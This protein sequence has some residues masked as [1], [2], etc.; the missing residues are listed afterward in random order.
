MSNEL[1]SRHLFD[2]AKLKSEKIKHQLDEILNNTSIELNIFEN[3]VMELKNEYITINERK[4]KKYDVDNSV[5]KLLEKGAYLLFVD[6]ILETTRINVNQTNKIKSFIKGENISLSQKEYYSCDSIK[7]HIIKNISRYIEILEIPKTITIQANIESGIF[8]QIQKDVNYLITIKNISQKLSEFK[9]S[10][11]FKTEMK[12]NIIS[13]LENNSLYHNLEIDYLPN[14]K[15]KLLLKHFDAENETVFL[16]Y[17]IEDVIFYRKEKIDLKSQFEKI[18]K[19]HENDVPSNR[20]CFLWPIN[21][22]DYKYNYS[23]F[24][25]WR[26][27]KPKR[28]IKITSAVIYISIGEKYFTEPQQ[29]GNEFS[30]EIDLE[31]KDKLQSV[32]EWEEYK[33]KREKWNYIDEEIS[34]FKKFED[35]YNTLK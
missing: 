15:I 31:S 11:I 34:K 23:E 9:E 26:R 27:D 32:N 30:F 14:I 35:L 4:F 24:W 33:K 18:G 28:L 8:S 21:K 13:Y 17:K 29:P 10:Q 6:Y 3:L 25:N 20:F 12:K 19:L 22:E 2:N 1:E 7:E 16:K 5:E